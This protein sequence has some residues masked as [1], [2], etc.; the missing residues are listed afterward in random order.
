MAV[1]LFLL[2]LAL[3]GGASA[4]ACLWGAGAALTLEFF[5]RRAFGLT[6]R[7]QLRALRTLPAALGYLLFL[8]GQMLKAGFLVLRLIYT[9][10]GETRPVLTEFQSP[11]KTNTAQA[12]LADS[13]TLT[14]GTITVRAEDGRFLVHAL[15]RSLTED[16]ARCGFA[17][18]LEKLERTE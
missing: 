8:L 1:A 7:A 9:R 3:S 11:L 5:C 10:G 18:R 6:L 17:R 13:I 12:A 14:A 16:F 15:D 4:D 2:W